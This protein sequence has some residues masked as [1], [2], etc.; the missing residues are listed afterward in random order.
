MRK[1]TKSVGRPIRCLV[2]DH[3]SSLTSAAVGKTASGPPRYRRTQILVGGSRRHRRGMPGGSGPDAERR[4]GHCW[5]PS[6]SV[7]AW[8]GHPA[9]ARRSASPSSPPPT[10]TATMSSSRS[11]VRGAWKP[12]LPA[13]MHRDRSIRGR[14][15][16]ELTLSDHVSYVH[17]PGP[18]RPPQRCPGHA[19]TIPRYRAGQGT[20]SGISDGLGCRR[21]AVPGVEPAL[22][23]ARGLDR[24]EGSSSGRAQLHCNSAAL[25]TRQRHGLDDLEMDTRGWLSRWCPP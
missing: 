2:A 5:A 6:T 4:C 23:I 9:A 1:S 21:R 13:P 18:L 16:T 8:V 24:P 20:A 17:E 15:V 12:Q 14:S 22:R 11:N 25:R 7:I 10:T 19:R 3:I